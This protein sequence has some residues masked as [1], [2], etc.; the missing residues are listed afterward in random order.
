M[1]HSDALIRA[2]NLEWTIARFPMRLT[3]GPQTGHYRTGYLGKN[4]GMQLSRADGVDFVIQELAKGE[5]IKKAP[6]N[7]Y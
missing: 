3:N 2:S 4:V 6:V 1:E 5:F 7:S